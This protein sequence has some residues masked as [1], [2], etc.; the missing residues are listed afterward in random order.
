MPT[1]DRAATAD[2]LTVMTERLEEA[3][4]AGATGLSSGLAYATAQ[5]AP[6][7]EVAALAQRVAGY[8]GVYATHLRDE[9]E[10]VLEAMRE[11]LDIARAAGVPVIFSHHKVA[12]RRN[13]GRSVETL[14]LLE[15]AAASNR[16]AWTPTRTP[17]G[18]PS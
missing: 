16:S 3:L 11:A 6:A 18:P 9:G 7:S 12:G 8:G 1:L 17:P 5:A 14:A 10:H 15:R 4:A 2:E 13:H